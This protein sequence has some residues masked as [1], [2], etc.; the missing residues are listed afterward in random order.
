MDKLKE[1]SEKNIKIFKSLIC[2]LSHFKDICEE[3]KKDQKY[4]SEIYYILD[5]LEDLSPDIY[6]LKNNITNQ[7]DLILE[8]LSPKNLEPLRNLND[9]LKNDSD[10]IMKAI[11]INPQALKFASEELRNN[12][13]FLIEIVSF[14]PLAL[15]FV[16]SKLQNNR[17]LVETAI[18]K[19]GWS[20]LY[21][22]DELRNDLE[23][24]M[25]AV[26]S[27]YTSV[28]CFTQEMCKRSEIFLEACKEKGSEII[29]DYASDNLKKDNLLFFDLIKVN[30]FTLEYFCSQFKDN[31]Q[32]ILYA[33]DYDISVFRFASSRLLNDK[34]FVIKALKQAKNNEK[35]IFDLISNRLKEDLEIILIFLVNGI[36]IGINEDLQAKIRSIFL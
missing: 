31:E 20:I 11:K 28:Q 15:A 3:E 12:I 27:S 32:K 9:Q 25:K 21:A 19:D 2:N 1:L 29:F 13:D 23:I 5:I 36:D 6:S 30:P 16:P 33:L 22:S 10:F 34:E 7:E 4:I 14:Q 18:E 17:K 8:K 24:A 26:K 35:F